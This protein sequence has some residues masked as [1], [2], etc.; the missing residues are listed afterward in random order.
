MI[1]LTVFPINFASVSVA[2]G[3]RENTDGEMDKRKNKNKHEEIYS[4]FVPIQM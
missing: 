3:R 2:L 4:S 1:T